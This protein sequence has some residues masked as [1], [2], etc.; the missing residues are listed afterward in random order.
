MKFCIALLRF[1][2]P[3]R[4]RDRLEVRAA[5]HRTTAQ[6]E[7]LAFTTHKLCNGGLRTVSG[8]RSINCTPEI[9]T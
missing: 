5:I 2:S 7:D 4:E 6:A 3:Q 8:L 1:V 9:P